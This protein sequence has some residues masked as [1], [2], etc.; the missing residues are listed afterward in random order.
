[1]TGDRGRIKRYYYDSIWS[2]GRICAKYGSSAR[3]ERAQ[4]RLDELVP[5]P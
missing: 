4:I 2:R 5:L 3:G 1:M